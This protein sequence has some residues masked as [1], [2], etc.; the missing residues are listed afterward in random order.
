[1]TLTETRQIFR[2]RTRRVR[3]QKLLASDRLNCIRVAREWV[4]TVAVCR[5]C[6]IEKSYPSEF[7]KH[8]RV[9]CECHRL[10]S[11]AYY[12]ATKRRHRRS[13]SA[14][15]ESAAVRADRYR[16]LLGYFDRRRGWYETVLEMFFRDRV[17][18]SLD[19]ILATLESATKWTSIPM[20]MPPPTVELT[21]LTDGGRPAVS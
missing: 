9:C 6:H 5:S 18:Y 21:A 7:R 8:R 12:H 2:S 10:R 17:G 4:M 19:F 11:L 20:T 3:F 15:H 13:K 1:M 16:R 14:P